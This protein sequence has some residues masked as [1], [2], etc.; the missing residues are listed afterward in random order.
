MTVEEDN[1]T[2]LPVG[3]GAEFDLGLGG[4]GDKA[5]E[6]EEKEGEKERE[7]EE[8][9]GFWKISFIKEIFLDKKKNLINQG[10]FNI[11]YYFALVFG[12]FL[13]AYLSL[14]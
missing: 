9:L 13:L 6:E 1:G 3:D 7:N 2:S 8:K 5:G 11:N 10:F 14:K 4:T 12:I